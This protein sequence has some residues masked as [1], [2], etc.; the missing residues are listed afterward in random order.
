[1]VVPM[2]VER[3]VATFDVPLQMA[4]SLLVL[5]VLRSG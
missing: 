1:M 5:P 4:L 2:E 3:D